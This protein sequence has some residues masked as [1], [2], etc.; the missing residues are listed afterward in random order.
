VI[1]V[2]V[3][4]IGMLLCLCADVIDKDGSTY[5]ALESTKI[6]VSFAVYTITVS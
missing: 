3:V 1:L 4:F 2:A 6:V 5:S